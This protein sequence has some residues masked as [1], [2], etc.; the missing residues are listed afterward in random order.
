MAYEYE[1]INSIGCVTSAIS[2]DQAVKEL[3][4]V[5]RKA[6][7]FDNY[8]VDMV[9]SIETYPHDYIKRSNFAKETYD[10]YM[11][12]KEEFIEAYKNEVRHGHELI[13]SV[14]EYDKIISDLERA[15]DEN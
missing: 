5:Y 4:E 9:K 7:A 1:R 13:E 12:S 6:K 2:T 14:E 15:N 11:Q 8:I 10:F 3:E